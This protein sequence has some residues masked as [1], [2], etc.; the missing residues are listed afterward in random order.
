MINETLD[1]NQPTSAELMA[2]LL[3]ALQLTRMKLFELDVWARHSTLNARKKVLVHMWQ[4]KQPVAVVLVS[5]EALKQKL[6]EG[7]RLTTGECGE[8]GRPV[9]LMCPHVLSCQIWQQWLEA[10]EHMSSGGI[11]TVIFK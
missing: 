2:R 9:G 1:V 4:G 8:A 10:V 7:I 3:D 6:N 5:K 11:V